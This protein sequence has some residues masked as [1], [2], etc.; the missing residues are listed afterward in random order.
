MSA[1]DKVTQALQ[2]LEEAGHLHLLTAEIQPRDGRPVRKA[3]KGIAAALLTC[4]PLHPTPSMVAKQVGNQGHSWVR[5]AAP[6][7]TNVDH[8]TALVSTGAVVAR[9]AVAMRRRKAPRKG[10]A[11]LSQREQV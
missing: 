6:E 10:W 2:L 8:R 7:V 5:R 9:G 11:C 4:S 1:A 3:Y